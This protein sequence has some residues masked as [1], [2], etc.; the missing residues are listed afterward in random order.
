MNNSAAVRFLSRVDTQS[1]GCW[2]WQG[3]VSSAG[4]GYLGRT[5]AHRRSY[6]LF[7]GSIPDGLVLDHLCRNAACVNPDHLEPVTQRENVRRG[8]KGEM[9]T[10][11]K[12]GHPYD[13]ENTYRR[14]NGQRDCRA[15]KRER[16]RDRQRRL[17]REASY[18][19]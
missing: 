13:L 4:Y 18:V 10:I 7:V 6:E 1:G 11:C 9:L 16:E 8:L 12:N 2:E 14:K 3:S 19:C 17:S 15:C 5:L